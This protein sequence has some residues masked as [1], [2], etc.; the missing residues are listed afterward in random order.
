[1]YAVHLN[2][3]VGDDRYRHMIP[4]TVYAEYSEWLK[5]FSVQNYEIITDWK[6]Q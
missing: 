6:L 3:D 2:V 4:Y 5:V 1:M